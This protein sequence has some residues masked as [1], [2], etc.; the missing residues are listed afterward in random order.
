MNAIGYAI[1]I[2]VGVAFAALVIAASSLIEGYCLHVLWGWFIVPMGAKPIGIAMAIG[3]SLVVGM[4]T[5][6]HIPKPKEVHKDDKWNCVAK[7]FA[8][9]FV[10]LAIGYVVKLFM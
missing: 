5:H 6:Q 2:I 8:W 7:V 3:I 1:G 9:P 4:L 10:M